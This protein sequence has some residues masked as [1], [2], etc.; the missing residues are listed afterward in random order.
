MNRQISFLLVAVLFGIV[1]GAVAALRFAHDEPSDD[2]SPVNGPQS[3]SEQII[4]SN[5][6]E[7]GPDQLAQTLETLTRTLNE[8]ISERSVLSQQLEQLQAEVRELQMN[9][10][11]SADRGSSERVVSLQEIED[12]FTEMGFTWQDRESIRHLEAVTRVRA[13]EL[14]DLARREGWIN[15]RRYSEESEALS[16]FDNPIR[17]E[18]GDDRYDRYLFA[19]GRPNRLVVGSVMETSP[20]QH[21]GFKHGDVIVRYDGERVFSNLH[22]VRLRSSGKLGAPII[23]EITRDGH[24]MQITIP[25]GPMGMGAGTEQVDP[26]VNGGR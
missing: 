24:P 11:V 10:R 23:V 3:P 15:S 1:L 17:D 14:N 13:V 4:V 16:T 26:R 8:E 21:A 12:R 9:R 2:L 7:L 20:A 25:R 18:L 19:M 22:L 6:S 5:P